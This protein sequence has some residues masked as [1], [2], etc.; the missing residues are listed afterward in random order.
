MRKSKMKMHVEAF[1][2][3]LETLVRTRFPTLRVHALSRTPAYHWSVD[4]TST[5]ESLTEDAVDELDM[6]VRDLVSERCLEFFDQRRISVG[7]QVL[8]RRLCL[9]A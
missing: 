3:E 7:T 5:D 2:R 8:P 9:A 6:Q 4:F 1:A